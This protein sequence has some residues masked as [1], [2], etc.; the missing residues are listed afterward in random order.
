[1]VF[2]KNTNTERKCSSKINN[3]P[4]HTKDNKAHVY[5]LK[6][7]CINNDCYNSLL[8]QSPTH[9]FME[10]VIIKI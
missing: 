3:V 5:K 2:L 7:V 10:V 9:E 4:V 1:M 8:Y 6:K